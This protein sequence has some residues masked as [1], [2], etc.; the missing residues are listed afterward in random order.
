MKFFHIGDLHFGKT[1]YNVPLVETD[2]PYWIE[3][4]LIAVEEK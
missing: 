2:H 1:L 4:F 3:Q